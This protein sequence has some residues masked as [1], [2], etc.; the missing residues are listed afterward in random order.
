METMNGEG[1]L[2][3]EN[4][5]KNKVHR[6]LAHSYLFYF[7]SFLLGLFLDFIFPLKFFEEATM[8]ILGSTILLLGTF[9]VVWAQKS[10]HNLKKE[11]LSKETFFVGPYRYTRS[12]THL[13]LFLLMLGFG[14]MAN[15]I[16]IIILS[17]LS[18]L[19]TK[20]LFIKKEEDILS[21]K[22]GAPYIEYKKSVRF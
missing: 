20:F 7:V 16:Y 17:F 14:I 1:R 5:F 8:A 19:F 15:G 22:Y 18:Y 9:L 6:V 2:E 10:S 13:G 4:P 11:N 3:V 21:E 12:P